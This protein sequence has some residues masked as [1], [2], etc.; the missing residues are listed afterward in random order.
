MD[1]D[2]IIKLLIVIPTSYSRVKYMINKG[3]QKHSCS[4]NDIRNMINNISPNHFLTV[5]YCLKRALPFYIDFINNVCEKLS[6]DTENEIEQIKINQNQFS[7]SDILKIYNEYNSNQQSDIKS[8]TDK[9]NKKINKI[10]N[11]FK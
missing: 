2:L 4:F 11:F 7:K 8:Q 9:L 10:K 5:E 1:N 3:E 6:Y